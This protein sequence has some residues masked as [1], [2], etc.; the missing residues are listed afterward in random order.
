MILLVVGVTDQ[1][2]LF[3]LLEEN[4]GMPLDSYAVTDRRGPWLAIQPSRIVHGNDDIRIECGLYFRLSCAFR[5]IIFLF[6]N[7]LAL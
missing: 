2:C 7:P 4:H 6:L 1:I 3:V 5:E